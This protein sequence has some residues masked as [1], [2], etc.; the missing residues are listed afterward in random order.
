MILK[1]LLKKKC[2]IIILIKT[3]A[4]KLT[5]QSSMTWNDCSCSV[6]NLYYSVLYSSSTVKS[7]TCF[8]CCFLILHWGCTW[9]HVITRCTSHW[10]CLFMLLLFSVF[11]SVLR[12]FK[13]TLIKSHNPFHSIEGFYFELCAAVDVRYWK[14]SPIRFKLGA[15]LI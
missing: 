5:D 10:S 13:W 15:F 2:M 6:C 14:E 9:P 1:D 11:L 7:D 4:L 3:K 8:C 12:C